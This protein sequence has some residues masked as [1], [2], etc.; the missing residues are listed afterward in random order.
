MDTAPPGTSTG[1]L[2]G[3]THGVATPVVVVGPTTDEDVGTADG[4][5]PCDDDFDPI[6]TGSDHDEVTA[7][8]P[9]G[10][11]FEP[12]SLDLASTRGSDTTAVMP[13]DTGRMVDGVSDGGSGTDDFADE[14]LSDDVVDFDPHSAWDDGDDVSATILGAVPTRKRKHIAAAQAD[15]TDDGATA[16]GMGGDAAGAPVDAHGSATKKRRRQGSRA[17]ARAA[18]KHGRRMAAFGAPRGHTSGPDLGSV[19]GRPAEDWAEW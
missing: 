6:P 1:I 2:T 13:V 16:T 19:E 5:L 3:P 15:D 7:V 8:A 12:A 4:A 17:T 18:Q 14:V 9:D 11:D 10:T